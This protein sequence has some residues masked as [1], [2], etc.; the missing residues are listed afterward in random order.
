MVDNIFEDSSV[1]SSLIN[2]SSVNSGLINIS[3]YKSSSSKNS[4]IKEELTPERKLV[5][6]VKS[7]AKYQAA[8]NSPKLLE[9][10]KNMYNDSKKDNFSPIMKRTY[11]KQVIKLL[12]VK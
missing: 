6:L 1:N 5:Y 11:E 7:I 4:Y 8:H 10:A 3:S 9:I 12:K 2:T